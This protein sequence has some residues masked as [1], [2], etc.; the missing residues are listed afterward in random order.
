METAKIS[1]FQVDACM[2]HSITEPSILQ[3][4]L[5]AAAFMRVIGGAWS[6][7]GVPVG[8]E[9]VAVVHALA[10]GGFIGFA[11][12]EVWKV[13]LPDTNQSVDCGG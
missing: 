8:P 6:F 11:C 10:I 12:L 1:L 3:A 2:R 9:L 13:I 4:R 7:K 5:N